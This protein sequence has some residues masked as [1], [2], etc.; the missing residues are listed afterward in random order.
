STIK[1]V[2]LAMFVLAL[3]WSAFVVWIPAKNMKIFPR[4]IIGAGFFVFGRVFIT[5]A[6][7]FLRKIIP[8]SSAMIAAAWWWPALLGLLVI[9]GSGLVAWIF[10]SLLS[11]K[12]PGV[13]GA[14]SVGSIFA[15]VTLG[16]C[17]YFVEPLLLLDGSGGLANIVPFVI[18]SLGMAVVFGLAA[19]TGPPIP[20]YF[21][22]GPLFLAPLAGICLLI[23]SPSL[24]WVVTSLTGVL[25][26]AA[27]IRHRVKLANGT[28]EPEPS[29]EEAA[30][31]DQQ[32]MVKLSQKIKRKL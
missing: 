27:W 6:L 7:T 22:L 10:L 23:A 15:V 13:V 11:N 14:R 29:P 9:I 16:A 12:L 3:S 20:H 5:V 19:R 4:F 31:V 32:K 26:L 25:C 2:S 18:A 24:L 17:S 30:M 28:E 21:T 1:I 8:D